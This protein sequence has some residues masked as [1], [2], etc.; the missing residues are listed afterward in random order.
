MITNIAQRLLHRCFQSPGEII[1]IIIKNRKKFIE[2]LHNYV[3]AKRSFAYENF[4]EI[5]EQYNTQNSKVMHSRIKDVTKKRTTTPIG[6]LKTK[7][8]TITVKKKK[9]KDVR[10]MVRL[11]EGLYKKCRRKNVAVNYN[12]ETPL[13]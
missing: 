1:K 2:Q 4:C 11:C 8:G 3:G 7:E 13:N 9:K 12:S 10:C 5:E 6:C